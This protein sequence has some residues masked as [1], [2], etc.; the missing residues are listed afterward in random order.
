MESKSSQKWI[1]KKNWQFLKVEDII[2]SKYG[3]VHIILSFWSWDRR[4]YYT[5]D[6]YCIDENKKCNIYFIKQFWKQIV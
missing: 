2:K 3:N 5:F 1:F 6:T 4:F